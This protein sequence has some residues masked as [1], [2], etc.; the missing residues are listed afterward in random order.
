MDW[1][2]WTLKKCVLADKENNC[3]DF[4]NVWVW[5]K[6]KTSPW[7]WTLNY[8]HD[9][10]YVQLGAVTFTS[11]LYYS[12]YIDDIIWP[13]S[14]YMSNPIIPYLYF[15]VAFMILSYLYVQPCAVTLITSYLYYSAIR[16]SD[17][18]IWPV[19]LRYSDDIIWPVLLRYSWY[20]LTCITPLRDS[21]DFIWPVLLR[22][23]DD[24]IRPVCPTVCRYVDY[25]LP[26]LLR[27]PLQW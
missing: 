15:S 6:E 7:P 13:V 3:M 18:I 19:L 25:I 21:D 14:I 1:T 9:D 23:S 8:F 4:E 20:Y 12:H 10:L 26:V 11:Y 17:S 27:D 2:K 24:I 5:R 16:Y 22:Y